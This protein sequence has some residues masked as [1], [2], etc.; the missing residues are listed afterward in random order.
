MCKQHR[1]SETPRQGGFAVPGPGAQVIPSAHPPGT[2]G[3]IQHWFYSSC[4]VCLCSCKLLVSCFCSRRVCPN[5]DTRLTVFGWDT[6]E[7]PACFPSAPPEYCLQSLSSLRTRDLVQSFHSKNLPS[8]IH[9]LQRSPRKSH[10]PKREMWPTPKIHLNSERPTQV[11]S[12]PFL[13]WS[14]TSRTAATLT[15]LWDWGQL[16]LAVCM[17]PSWRTAPLLPTI[18]I[19]SRDQSDA[20]TN[21]I[22]HWGSHV[23]LSHVPC[24]TQDG[25]QLLWLTLHHSAFWSYLVRI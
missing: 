4:I 25:L 17:V 8:N 22:A 3:S 14:S 23:P 13:C 18:T 11:P 20:Q 19:C 1:Y 9:T 15:I 12:Y 16:W 21:S 5:S 6:M 2:Q 24:I 10:L 7:K